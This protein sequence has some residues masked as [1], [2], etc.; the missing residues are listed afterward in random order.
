LGIEVG[1]F[2]CCYCSIGAAISGL[3]PC[4]VNC[5]LNGVSC[6]HAKNGGNTGTQSNLGNTLGGFTSNVVEVGGLSPDNGTQAYDSVVLSRIGDSPRCRRD[7]KRPRNP[8][9][10]DIVRIRSVPDK[11]IFGPVEQSSRDEFIEPADNNGKLLAVGNEISLMYVGHWYL[12]YGYRD[13]LLLSTEGV[14]PVEGRGLLLCAVRIV[15]YTLERRVLVYFD[16]S[17]HMCTFGRL[18]SIPLLC[19]TAHLAAQASIVP[20]QMVPKR[21]NAIVTAVE[22]AVPSVVNISTETIVTRRVDPF[23]SFRGRLFDDFFNDFFHRHGERRFKTT[24]LGSG[25][26]VDESGLVVTND[27]VVRRA[28]KITVTFADQRQLE[29]TILGEEIESDLAVLQIEG[30][31][32]FPAIKL[33]TSSDLMIGET[34]IALGN[35]YGLQS[36]VTVGVLSANNRSIFSDGKEV[37]KDLLQTDAAI[38]PGNSGGPLVNIFGQLIGINTAIHAE[39]EGIGFAIPVDRVRKTLF[40]MLDSGSI[41]KTMFG[42]VFDDVTTE[43]AKNFEIEPGTSGAVVLEVE[44]DSPAEIAGL[45]TGDLVVE[46]DGKPISQAI[47]CLRMILKKEVGDTLNLKVIRKGTAKSLKVMLTA[48][49]RPSGRQLAAKRLGLSVQTLTASLAQMF[50]LGTNKGVLISN[51]GPDSPGASFLRKGDVILSINGRAT[52]TT[53]ALGM[54]LADVGNGEQVTLDIARRN[55]R[56]RVVLVTQ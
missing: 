29:A 5:L 9:D 1:H 43:H 25:V 53:E 6:D 32:P 30:E 50:R 45:E 46:I 3:C 56:I 39:A 22:Q 44:K 12:L 13:I 7:L 17:N 37:F 41:K 4:P 40:A 33:G 16:G 20:E 28:S 2:D 55:Y 23:P 54:V 42:S 27:H 31:G 35:P 38:N 52:D 36:S 49:P 26:I 21:R 8:V 19:L 51:V 11:G 10:I 15:Y 47:D 24:S 34:V 14:K 18:L 48:V